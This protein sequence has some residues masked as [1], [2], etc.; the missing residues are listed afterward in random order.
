MLPK[1]L[2]SV[3]TPLS[4]TGVNSTSKSEVSVQSL[5]VTV[6]WFQ[7]T[8]DT[9]Y[10][11]FVISIVTTFLGSGEF[12]KQNHGIY[13]F[14]N[15]WKHPTGV[16]IAS[17]LKRPSGDIDPNYSYL[18]LKGVHLSPFP[19]TRIRKLIRVLLG[20]AKCSVTRI[21]L[22]IDDYQKRIDIDEV[23]WA[24][25][26]HKVIGFRNTGEYKSFGKRGDVGKQM[27]FGRRGKKGGNKRFVI[28]DK[29]KESKGKIDSIRM[30]LNL[31][32]EFA[33]QAA[34]DIAYNN[35]NV[36]GVI[37]HG[38][39]CGAID[40]RDR[41]GKEDK[42]PGRRERLNFWKWFADDVPHIVCSL[43]YKVQHVDKLIK[44]F[45]FLAPSFYVVMSV[46]LNRYDQ[47]GYDVWF[48]N[49]VFDGERRLS[50]RHKYLL[51]NA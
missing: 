8:F 45:E 29:S 7:C 17:G 50:S 26:N 15:A 51:L 37:V 23:R 18:E 4:S 5:Q 19:V 20:K 38:Y 48:W 13:Y 44:W 16:V 39:I 31:Y 30:E 12:E 1:N 22:T 43:P 9:K 33:Q 6:D 42:N 32:Q 11:D 28:Y 36:F 25:D 49:M 21:D 47:E 35:V 24:Y 10:L 46:L 2:D 34:K 41:Q 14:K 3:G 40:F 27:S